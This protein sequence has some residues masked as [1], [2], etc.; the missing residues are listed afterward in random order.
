MAQADFRGGPKVAQ[1]VA[2]KKTQKT[3]V[4]WVGGPQVARRLNQLGHVVAQWPTLLEWA[5]G[6]PGKVPY[7]EVGVAHTVFGSVGG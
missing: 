7:F 4:F 6:Q 1:Q 5:T 3:A 2:Q